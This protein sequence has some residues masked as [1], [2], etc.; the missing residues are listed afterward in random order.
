MTARTL[1]DLNPPS[2]CF[3]PKG[4]FSMSRVLPA[5]FYVLLI[6]SVGG[7]EPAELANG[8]RGNGTGLMFLRGG[9]HLRCI[10]DK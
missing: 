6:S 7:A 3:L 4:D 10:G 1:N 2:I 8:W 9:V 5:L